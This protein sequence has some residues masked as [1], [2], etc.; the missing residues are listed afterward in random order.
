MD[1]N[2]SSDW[3]SRIKY[4]CIVYIQA[5]GRLGNTVQNLGL[6]FPLQ[7]AHQIATVSKTIKH[8]EVPEVRPIDFNCQ[9]VPSTRL[10]N[11]PIV[12]SCE[13]NP[14]II[15]KIHVLAAAEIFRLL[16][17]KVF[18]YLHI[19]QHAL[20]ADSAQ[21]GHE[22]VRGRGHLRTWNVRELTLGRASVRYQEVVEDELSGRLSRGT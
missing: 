15:Y 4:S 11:C 1:L 8:I 7:L 16:V 20:V 3:H 9:P 14:S 2:L 5:Y 6:R 22:W 17:K 13:L 12:R 21:V 10:I 19:E 18:K